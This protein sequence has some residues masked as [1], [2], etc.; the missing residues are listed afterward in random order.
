MT[1]TLQIQNDRLTWKV[2]GGFVCQN[3]LLAGDERAGFHYRATPNGRVGY[4]SRITPEDNAVI[5]S[6]IEVRRIK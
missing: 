3:L 2:A 5:Y 6:P 4:C 1:W